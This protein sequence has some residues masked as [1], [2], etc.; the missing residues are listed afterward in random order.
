MGL[1]R[2]GH[3][4]VTEQEEVTSHGESISESTPVLML[5]LMKLTAYI[6]F[7]PHTLKVLTRILSCSVMIPVKG[8]ERGWEVSKCFAFS[9]CR[10]Q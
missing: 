6:I 1:Q 10:S 8:I 9:S 2:A 5:C 3:D 7:F 4:L